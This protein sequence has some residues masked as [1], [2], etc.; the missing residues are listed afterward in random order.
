MQRVLTLNDYCFL[1]KFEDN[2]E[3]KVTVNPA[4][5]AEI[6]LRRW[7]FEVRSDGENKNGFV[8]HLALAGQAS[9]VSIDVVPVCRS[10]D[11]FR[12]E[13]ASLKNELDQMVLAAEAQIKELAATSAAS[14]SS[15]LDPQAVWTKMQAYPSQEELFDYFNS[16]EAS[17]RQK[18]ADYILVHAN[19]FKGWG[20]VFA[21]HYNLESNRLEL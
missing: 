3:L 10:L 13:L 11:E 4:K 7:L 6:M 5:E 19:M 21:E 18:I 17:E 14:E 8:I 12:A 20:P 15:G 1:T 9:G 2:T 16:F